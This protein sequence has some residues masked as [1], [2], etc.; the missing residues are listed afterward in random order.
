[1]KEPK[2]NYMLRR[3]HPKQ[4]RDYID[5]D[6]SKKLNPDEREWLEKFTKEYYGADFEIKE[7][8]VKASDLVSVIDKMVESCGAEDESKEVRLLYNR[9]KMITKDKNEMIQI[10]NNTNKKDNYDLRKFRSVD[11]YYKDADDKFTLDKSHKYKNTIHDVEHLKDCNGRVNSSGRDVMCNGLKSNN[12]LI[13]DSLVDED[14]PE[15]C[16]TIL[17]RELIDEM[18]ILNKI[19]K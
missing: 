16:N 10:N 17:D 6:Y 7:T 11:K 18:L 4:R 15:N 19:K 1:M 2:K 8:Y 12:D 5:Y 3:N 9:T 14:N 13:I